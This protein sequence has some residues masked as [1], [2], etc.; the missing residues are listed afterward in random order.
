MWNRIRL[1]LLATLLFLLGLAGVWFL[2]EGTNPLGGIE[3][4]L[5]A[6]AIMARAAAVADSLGLDRSGRVVS[7]TMRPDKE[8]LSAVYARHGLEKGNELLR[9][10]APG[11]L[12]RVTWDRPSEEIVVRSGGSG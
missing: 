1:S 5:G 4:G 8:I 9:K 7:V 11:Y 6:D 3:I 10:K 2:F 12:W